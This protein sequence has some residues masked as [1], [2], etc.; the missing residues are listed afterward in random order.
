LPQ[1]SLDRKLAI[2][3]VVFRNL[4]AVAGALFLGWSAQALILLYFFDT[5]GG[6]LAIFAALM[7]AYFDKPGSSL[8]DRFYALGTALAL[9]AF[10]AAFM[11]IP[12]GMPVVF[13]MVASSYKL[14]DALAQPGFV[15]AVIGVLAAALAGTLYWAMRI[16]VEGKRGERLL[17][18]EFTLIF[19]RWFF[20]IVAVY[21]PFVLLF[22]FGPIIIVAVYAILSVYTELYPNRF[23]RFFERG[24]GR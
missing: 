7:F 6:M 11:A 24:A 13:V 5:L 4:I 15:Y 19:G 18:R 9:S 22:Q 16:D 8:F 14:Q 12:L 20:V 17:K 3:E 21:L 1:S 10:T 23:V 2:V